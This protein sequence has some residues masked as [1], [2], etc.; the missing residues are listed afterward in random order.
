MASFIAA[1]DSRDQPNVTRMPESGGMVAMRNGLRS[2]P[3]SPAM[4]N[5]EKTPRS[6]MVVPVRGQSSGRSITLTGSSMCL[7]TRLRTRFANSRT[8]TAA[9]RQAG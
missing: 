1:F 3:V 7:K 2:P 4:T 5:W 8:A 6:Q 9:V